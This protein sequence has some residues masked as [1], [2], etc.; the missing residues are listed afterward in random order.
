MVNIGWAVFLKVYGPCHKPNKQ[1][2][3][4]KHVFAGCFHE[5][6]TEII[7]QAQRTIFFSSNLQN[8][9]VHL[10]GKIQTAE[11]TLQI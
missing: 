5:N 1:V 8:R 4:S 7:P 11:G 6:W 10:Y 3:Q 2:Q 9:A